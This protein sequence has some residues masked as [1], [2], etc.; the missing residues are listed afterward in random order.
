MDGAEV[1][2]AP[3]RRVRQEPGLLRETQGDKRVQPSLKIQCHGLCGKEMLFSGLCLLLLLFSIIKR[4]F[5]NHREG[6]GKALL[7]SRKPDKTSI[8]E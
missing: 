5:F 2:G 3:P 1:R 7:Y 6:V 8:E 4:K